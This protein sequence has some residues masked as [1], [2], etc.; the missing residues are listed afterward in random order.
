MITLILVRHGE[1]EHNISNLTGG[2]SQTNLT[3]KG[4]QQAKVLAKRLKQELNKKTARIVSSDLT[5][6]KET[7]EIIGNILGTVPEYTKSLRELNNGIAA[8]KKKDEVTKYFNEATY[9]LLDWQTYPGAETWRKFHRRVSNYLNS[10]SFNDNKVIIMVTHA[11]TI[12]HIISWWLMLN[13][14]QMEKTSFH[15]DLASI[16]VLDETI[17]NPRRIERLNDTQHL[18]D[19]GYKNPLKLK[20]G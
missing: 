3:H 19:I 11:G 15:T 5:R 2:W 20:R 4:I 7:A 14:E 10:F 1:A 16:T 17:L 18:L 13:E 8:G 6:A 12:V 9:P